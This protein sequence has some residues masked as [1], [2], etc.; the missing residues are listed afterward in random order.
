MNGRSEMTEGLAAR[1]LE[2]I[3]AEQ[4]AAGTHWRPRSSPTASACRARRSTRPC[5]CCTRRACSRTSRTAATSSAR[6]AAARR[7]ELGLPTED[8]LSR[9]YFQIADDRLHGRLPAQV[10]ESLL[11][12][13]YDLTR[14]QLTAVLDPHL[15]RRAGPSAAP[16]MAGSSR[17]MLVTPE[18]LLQTYRVRMALEPA[19]LLEPGYR[20]EPAAIER[21]R[22]AELRLLDGAL[23][24]IR[25]TRCTSAASASTRASSAP[26]ATRSSSTRCAG[27]TA[28]AASSPTAAWS[29][30]TAT[31]SSAASISTSWVARAGP[32]HG[33]GRGAARAPGHDHP[34]PRPDPAADGALSRRRLQLRH[35]GYLH[36]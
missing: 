12:E 20:L 21:L 9:V 15:P 24:T 2:H 13:R 19:A 8:E 35:S 7:S 1:I 32:Q 5:A 23:E 18:A 11:R 4:L 16:A 34:Q 25:P 31:A 10:S 28:S 14:A 36:F 27:S 3:R 17:E 29:S 6:R 22:A 26:A 30:A 33:G